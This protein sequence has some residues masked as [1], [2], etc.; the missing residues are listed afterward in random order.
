MAHKWLK[1][2]MPIGK[3]MIL[4][5]HSVSP[6]RACVEGA[7]PDMLRSFDRRTEEVLSEANDQKV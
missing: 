6:D 4:R 3:N 5:G 7:E 2:L 1:W